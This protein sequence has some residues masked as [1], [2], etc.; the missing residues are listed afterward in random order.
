MKHDS[1]KT[2][3]QSYQVFRMSR[4]KLVIGHFLLAILGV[5][6]PVMFVVYAV[7]H[8]GLNLP[9]NIWLIIALVTVLL[10]A[11]YLNFFLLNY[12]FEVGNGHVI[13]SRLTLRGKK[14]IGQYKPSTH[15]L[16]FGE[17]YSGGAVT[18]VL[19][20]SPKAGGKEKR[21][22]HGLSKKKITEMQVAIGNLDRHEPTL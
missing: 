9:E 10:L 19:Y 18:R 5:F 6:M 20:I 1:L 14:I 3:G 7:F 13:V 21:F 11:S 8:L 4:F 16:R 12:T 22:A 15:F 17:I 2:N